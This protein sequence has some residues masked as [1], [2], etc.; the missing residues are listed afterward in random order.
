MCIALNTA[1]TQLKNNPV[2]PSVASLSHLGTSL[3]RRS[4]VLI[5]WNVYWR[6]SVHLAGGTRKI[7]AS[8]FSLAS[9]V[10]LSMLVDMEVFLSVVFPF[11]SLHS[12]AKL[13]SSWG[14]DIFPFI[15]EVLFS[16]SVWVVDVR[17]FL[18]VPYLDINL[19]AFHHLV[20]TS[21]RYWKKI[22]YDPLSYAQ[23]SS[24]LYN[25]Y[26]SIP[27]YLYIYIY[28]CK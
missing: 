16:A 19:S 28:N 23:P 21:L 7:R 14:V 22:A 9:A 2:V 8:V 25:L 26:P 4:I 18:S 5:S 15:Y 12:R 3:G 20:W 17:V 1:L 24:L 27:I 6:N 10:S 11:A 13:L